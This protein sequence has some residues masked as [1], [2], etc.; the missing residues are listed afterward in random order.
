MFLAR[1]L[2]TMGVEAHIHDIVVSF[3]LLRPHVAFV[4]RSILFGLH[5][6]LADAV[7]HVS[8]EQT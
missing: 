4:L 3:R 6:G 7:A 1:V 2:V 8:G 5:D